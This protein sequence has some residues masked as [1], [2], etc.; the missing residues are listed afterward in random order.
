MKKYKVGEIV[1]G[2]VTGI[3]NYGIFLLIDD[4]ITGLIHISELSDSFVKDVSEYA[5]INEI[6]K[7]RV[8]EYD[9]ENNKMKLSV[10]N[11][12]YREE[13]NKIKGIVETKTGFKNLSSELKKWI[14]NKED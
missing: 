2:K 5:D 13:N 10:K 3:E 11:L 8:L 9:E 4:D 1:K 7:A 14:V 12:D 6:I